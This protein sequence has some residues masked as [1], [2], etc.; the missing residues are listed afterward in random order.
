MMRFDS[1]QLS[2]TED[3]E[4]AEEKPGRSSSVSPV[5]SVVRSLASQLDEVT[6]NPEPDVAGLLW[7]ELHSG[8][9]RPLYDGAERLAMITDSDGL[10]GQRRD[11][12][13]REIHLSTVC[14]ALE[15]GRVPLHGERVPANVRDLDFTVRLKAGTTSILLRGVRYG[16][17]RRVRL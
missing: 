7:M 12:T 9:V 5:S 3:T 10:T 16:F 2:T 14:N 15:D 6:Q 11:V 8:D 1:K 4:D 17:V 13:V